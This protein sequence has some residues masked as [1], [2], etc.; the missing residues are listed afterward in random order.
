M[1]SIKITDIILFATGKPF[2]VLYVKFVAF[3]KQGLK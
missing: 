1:N 2:V 3:P